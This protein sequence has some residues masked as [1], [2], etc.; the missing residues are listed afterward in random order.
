[1][2]KLVLFFILFLLSACMT[3]KSSP[4]LEKLAI[5]DADHEIV[6]YS[7]EVAKTRSAR[8]KG[9]MYRKLMPEDQGMLL[10]YRDSTRMAIWMKNTY[11]PLDIIF[12]NK[13]GEIVK[14]HTSAEPLSLKTIDSAEKVQAVLELNAGQIK[15]HG[16]SVGNRVSYKKFPEVEK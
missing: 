6:S 13:R 1:M 9:L 7:V 8:S 10:Y 4:S 11:I 3:S 5:V 2:P 16:I 14:I 12:I 15:K